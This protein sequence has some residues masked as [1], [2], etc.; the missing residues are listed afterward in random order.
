MFIRTV[1]DQSSIYGVTGVL[2]DGLIY[3]KESIPETP[4]AIVDEKN[5]PKLRIIQPTK[6]LD[7]SVNRDGKFNWILL[8]YVTLEDNDPEK[9][10][11]EKQCYELWTPTE[12]RLYYRDKQT[13]G[14]DLALYKRYPHNCGCVPFVQ[15]PHSN[16]NIDGV[17]E[18]MIKD[19]SLINR[20]IF[21]YCSLADEIF[22]LQTFSQLVIAG[23]KGEINPIVVGSSRAFTVPK[24]SP[25]PP[26][27]I[28]PD[29]GQAEILIKHIARCVAEIYRLAVIRKGGSDSKDEYAT[30]Y[31]R[32]VDFEDTEAMLASKAHQMQ[33]Y[34]NHLAGIV[35]LWRGQKEQL[36]NAEYP[37]TFE[38]K[39][40]QQEISDAMLLDDLM[41]GKTFMAELRKHIGR[42]VM[43]TLGE[44]M[45]NKIEKE[46]EAIE[47]K[48]LPTLIDEEH[49]TP[50]NV[51]GTPAPKKDTPQVTKK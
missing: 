21:N 37:K 36:W 50:T 30:A 4:T 1:C 11:G 33:T 23:D 12:M 29:A 41:M 7:W 19:I 13:K 22:Y 17:P 42:L 39:S 40:V 46:I 2:V 49:D 44:D 16:V 48:L 51:S 32:A 10:R 26:R 31:G 38:V 20:A 9:N 8:T 35:N 28:A 6:L 15:F 43:P 5:P 47:E 27:Y 14:N 3:D 24:T 18:S 25:F 45:W 34:E